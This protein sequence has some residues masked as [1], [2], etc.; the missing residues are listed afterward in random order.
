MR[1]DEIARFRRLYGQ[2]RW[3]TVAVV[4]IAGGALAMFSLILPVVLAWVG[5][6]RHLRAYVL[7]ALVV[8]LPYV[9]YLW[10]IWAIGRAMGDIAKGRLIQPALASAL[11]R[12]GMALAIGGVTCVFISPVLV[13]LVGNAPIRYLR[14][15]VPSITL[16]M[17]GVALFLLGRVIDQAN[18]V[19]SEL[20]EML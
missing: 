20:D 18:R 6:F 8:N 17:V 9:F 10:G 16:G 11:R 5:P 15:D 3:L 13:R 2:Y 7:P 1:K 4:I 19:Q 14:L 12:A